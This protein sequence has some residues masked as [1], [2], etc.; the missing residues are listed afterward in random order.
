MDDLGSG[1][2]GLLDSA[3]RHAC[4]PAALVLAAETGVRMAARVAVKIL[5]RG[6]RYLVV[7]RKTQVECETFDEAWKASIPYFAG[8]VR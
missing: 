4:R 3:I 1:P 8:R 2:G 5:R 7:G 6:S